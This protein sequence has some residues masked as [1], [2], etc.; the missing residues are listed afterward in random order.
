MSSPRKPEQ[1]GAIASAAVVLVIAGLVFVHAVTTGLPGLVRAAI[2][3]LVATGGAALLIGRLARI[4]APGGQ[5]DS[6]TLLRAALAGAGLAVFGVGALAVEVALSP[7]LAARAVSYS[8]YV[9]ALVQ[10][11]VAAMIPAVFLVVAVLPGV[12]EELLFRGVVRGALD[13]WS[14]P[15]RVLA[16]GFLFALV[17]AEPLVLAPLFYVGCVLTL[18]AERT[19]GWFAPAVAH[20]TLNAVN[21]IVMP[22]LLGTDPPSLWVGAVFVCVGA[23]VATLAMSGRFGRG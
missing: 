6:R 8:A 23:G 18:M 16:V 1:G 11:D 4:D 20:I 5:R 17:H 19:G 9:E 21:A 3:T 12:F 7:W 10:P 22:R 2:G 15:A 13:G 14:M